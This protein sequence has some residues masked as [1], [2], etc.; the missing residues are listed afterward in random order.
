MLFAQNPFFDS[1]IQRCRDWLVNHGGL[2]IEQVMGFA[3]I[4]AGCVVV[5]VVGRM[6]LK[7]L[8]GNK[9]RDSRS[10]VQDG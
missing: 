10:E 2:T 1:P 3:L 6:I 9:N 8:K 5:L 4:L 7:K